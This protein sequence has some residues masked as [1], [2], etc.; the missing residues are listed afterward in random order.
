MIGAYPSGLVY[1]EDIPPL[2]EWSRYAESRSC[3]KLKPGLW[4]WFD[5]DASNE[6]GNLNVFATALVTAASGKYTREVFGRIFLSD[7]VNINDTR[8]APMALGASQYDVLIEFF[9][10]AGPILRGEKLHGI[11]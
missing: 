8:F 3:I 10:H 5:T 9:R 6:S 2:H 11:V 7:G 1:Q 4:M